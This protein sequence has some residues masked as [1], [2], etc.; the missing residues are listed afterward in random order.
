M[1]DQLNQNRWLTIGLGA[2][3]LFI[4]IGALAG[5]L[6][7]VIDPSGEQLGMSTEWLANSPFADFFVPGLLLLIVNGIGNLAGGVAT[8]RR[9]RYAGNL[10]MVLGAF[11]VIWIVAQVWW[12]GF[13]HWLQPLYFVFGLIES[14]LGI[15]IWREQR[16]PE[17]HDVIL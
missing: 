4:G 8:L 3:Q 10:A 2:L 5:G 15:Q 1:V 13:S 12:I 14:T 11:L 9:Y 17:E 6:G 16:N 7:M